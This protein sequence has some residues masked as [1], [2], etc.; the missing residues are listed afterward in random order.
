M[1]R[2]ID[3]PYEQTLFFM[4][5]IANQI[6]VLSN[7][8]KQLEANHNAVSNEIVSLKN[9]IIALQKKYN[10]SETVAAKVEVEPEIPL[11][12]EPD[13]IQNFLDKTGG[14]TQ[15]KQE[16]S[17]NLEAFIGENVISKIGIII[18]IIG[19]VIG[20][21][22]SIDHDLVT[23]QMRLIIGLCFGLGLLGLGIKLKSKY[24][25]YSAVL[26]S[27]A[28]AILY[29][30]VFAAYNYYSFISQ[31]WA[32]AF[33][34]FITSGGVYLALWHKKQVIAHIGLVGAY[35]VPLLLSDGSGNIGFLFA[36]TT[37]VNVGILAI[38]FSKNWRQL[39]FT[40]FAF[41]W[42][43]FVAWFVDKYI[44]GEHE[45]LALLFLSANFIIFY[46]SILIFKLKQLDAFDKLDVGLIL[47]NTFVFF[48]LSYATI[49]SDPM[50]QKF[51]GL[52]TILVALVHLTA[53]YAVF[54]RQLSDKNLFQFLIGLSIV[55]VVL[56]G[57]I[58][59]DGHWVT[60]LWTGQALA[61]FVVGRKQSKL[62]YEQMAYPMMLFA[63]LS[64]FQDW[65]EYSQ[66]RPSLEGYSLLNINFLTSIIFT[67]AFGFIAYLQKTTAP[68]LVTSSE[69]KHKFQAYLAPAVLVFAGFVTFRLE[70]TQYW[71]DKIH[72]ADSFNDKMNYKHLKT[73]W[74][75]NYNM[76]YCLVLIVLNIINIHSKKL[77][78]VSIGVG[79]FS[80]LMFLILGL[81]GVSELREMFL[82]EHIGNR[83]FWMI[84]IR[85]LS[86]IIFGLMVFGLYQYKDSK[87][88]D[89]HIDKG[90][91]IAFHITLIWVLS[92][93]LL[94]WLDFADVANSYKLWL[95]ILWGIYSLTLISYG[96]LKGKKILRIIAISIFG[97]VL[98]KLFV[99]DI[100]H[101]NSLSKTIV[102]ISLGVLLLLISFLYN[103]FKARISE[104]NEH[105]KT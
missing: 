96:I 82:S 64:M 7:R 14:R 103:K 33:M 39:R 37:L 11:R 1:V 61:L 27:G 40:S 46:A 57:P 24:D 67:S 3:S 15:S 56:A 79:L 34:F 62:F 5:D 53:A 25:L 89:F 42:L 26:S 28:L 49:D 20:T 18:T 91:G 59:F 47:S 41:T 77:S 102:F 100:A 38:A 52:F 4:N 55:F 65:A 98:V 2:A 92:S 73:I 69:F 10:S 43:I 78:L 31:I 72:Y 48:G 45:G 12:P 54:K 63:A 70:L 97:V 36:F 104:E 13:I 16:R 80:A 88:L 58:Q 32:F 95:S 81:Y 105:N 23:P 87:L 66:L 8:L 90:F 21:K 44:S 17:N 83:S 9:E 76:L 30:T 6:L 29:F 74:E 85:Y 51:L 75:V 93:E 99:Y 86:L 50:G 35:A 22:Y 60:L 101:H 19:A 68:L 71:S 84:G 94:H